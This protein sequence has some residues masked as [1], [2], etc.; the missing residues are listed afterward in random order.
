MLEYSSHG[1]WI[2]GITGGVGAGK[3]TV[4][5]LLEQEYGACVIQADQIGHLVMDPGQPCYKAVIEHFGKE[6][7]V[8]MPSGMSTKK[9]DAGA[10]Q[11]DSEK[12]SASPPIDRKK[13]GSYVFSDPAELQALNDIVHPAVKTWILEKLAEEKEK[14]TSVCVVEAALLLESEYDRFCDEVWYVYASE[15][16]RIQRLISSRGYTEEYARQI[17]D[18]QKSDEWYRSR[19]DFAVDNS[20]SQEETALQVRRRMEVLLKQHEG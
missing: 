10:I 9:D 19:V 17:F 16:T 14:Q 11:M 4:L 20:G 8:G 12:I 15:E 2:I 3:S 6:F 18:S 7:L 5:A 1:T 13:L